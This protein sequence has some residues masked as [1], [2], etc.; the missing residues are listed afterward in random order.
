LIILKKV[1]P[2]P[3][4]KRFFLLFL[5]LQIATGNL[6]G[7]ELARL[8]FVWE[9]YK[10]HKKEDATLTFSQFLNLHYNSEDHEKQDGHRHHN[11]P[12]HCANHLLVVQV[13]DIV[14][15]TLFNIEE[16]KIFSRSFLLK[17]TPFYCLHFC[18]MELVKRL[19]RPPSVGLLF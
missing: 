1:L 6:F 4:M 10:E 8:P 13:A 2:L 19:L 5:V 16:K 3:P 17:S 18:S 9:H 11:L 12:L 15:F 14:D 7:H